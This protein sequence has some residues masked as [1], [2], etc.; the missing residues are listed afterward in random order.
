MLGNAVKVGRRRQRQR[1]TSGK[2]NAKRSQWAGRFVLNITRDE[3]NVREAGQNREL[4]RSRDHLVRETMI[5]V[6]RQG[7]DLRENPNAET[8]ERIR[9]T[10]FLDRKTR[11]RVRGN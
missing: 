10:N 9:A 3:N 2:Q 5:G 6:G 8:K 1:A 11:E 4:P 7:R